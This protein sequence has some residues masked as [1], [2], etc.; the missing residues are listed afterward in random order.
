MNRRMSILMSVVGSMVL[1]WSAVG[2]SPRVLA[3]DHGVDT[4]T[5]TVT[6]TTPFIG[7]AFTQPFMLMTDLSA[8]VNRDLLAPLPSP[9]QITGNLEGKLDEGATFTISLP[10]K[11]LGVGHDFATGEVD[12][13]G[14][15]VYAVDFQ[16]NLVGDPFLT[17]LETTGWPT[18]LSSVAVTMGENEV[19]GGSVTVWS[20]EATEFPTGFG[21]DGKLFTEDDP[22]GPLDAGWTVIDLNAEPFT[23][24][25]DEVVEIPIIEGEVGL[26]DLSRLGWT[27]AF[28]VLTEELSVR[29]PFS[30]QKQIDWDELIAEYRPQIESAE[31]AGDATA[32]NMALLSFAEKLH[33]GHAWVDLPDGYFDREIGGSYG[34]AL[35]L[36]DDG[37]VVVRCVTEPSSAAKAGVMPGAEIV[38]WDEVDVDEALSA[39]DLL[40]SESTSDGADDQRLNLL[41]RGPVG[42]KIM[43][44]FINPG[45]TELRTEKLKAQE[46][47]AGLT[48]SCGRNLSGPTEMPVEVK[49]LPSGVGYIAVNGFTDDLTLTLQSWEWALRRLKQLDVPGLIVDLRHNGGGLSKLPIYMAGSFTKEPFILATQVYVDE[50]GERAATA[51][52]QVLPAPVSWDKPVAVLVGPECVSAC[53]LLAAA[54]ARNPDIAIVGLGATAGTEGGVFPWLLPTGIQFRAPLIGFEDDQGKIFLEGQGVE[55]TIRVPRTAETLQVGPGAPDAVLV[56][57]EEAI[58]NGTT[59][60]A[61]SE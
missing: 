16:V 58:L 29:Y 5:G 24:V 13:E 36:T 49:L 33:D 26:R 38:E 4:L 61:G 42:T 45:E 60:T 51:V 47:S 12:S 19:F 20:P 32:Y 9:V 44:G 11:P 7:R 17:E 15:Q 40:F 10:I 23:R 28:D 50:N 59:S 8:F 41:A 3:A 35:G 57:A 53:E 46:D 30:E 56:A 14:V 31:Q 2:V 37:K 48:P 52:D 22:L 55:P 54:I 21:P 25:R 34:I 27:E 39:V 18:A 6:I 1:A 43:V